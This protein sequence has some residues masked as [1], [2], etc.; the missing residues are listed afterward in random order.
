MEHGRLARGDPG[1]GPADGYVLAAR[2]GMLSVAGVLGSL[3]PASTVLL[4]RIVY[5]ERL[6]PIQRVGLAVAVVGVG[7]VGSG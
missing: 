1:E 2:A 7:L 3:Y 5:G 4:A 6:R